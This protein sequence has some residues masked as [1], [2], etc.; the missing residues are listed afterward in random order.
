MTHSLPEWLP[1]LLDTNGSW[2]EILERLYSVFTSDFVT[3]RP[4]CDGLPVLPDGKKLDGDS[5]EEGFWHL[6]TKTDPQTR[7]RLLDAPRAK[8]LGWC[9]ATIEN[10]H[11]PDVL[12]FDYEEGSGRLRRYLW[13]HECDYLVVLEKRKSGGKATA[14][15]LITAFYLDGPSSRRRI[16]K[17]YDAR[18]T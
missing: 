17:K 18:E 4:R 15:M 9:R 5:H 16:R 2:D 13:L 12:V 6:I 7:D 14:Y 8:R 3:N 11:P 10:C 1:E